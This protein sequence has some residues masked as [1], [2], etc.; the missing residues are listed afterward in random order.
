M[1]TKVSMEETVA[2]SSMINFVDL[3]KLYKTGEHNFF[4]KYGII[5]LPEGF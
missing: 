2:L 3:G 1:K 5:V 4:N